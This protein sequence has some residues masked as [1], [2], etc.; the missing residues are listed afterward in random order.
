MMRIPINLAS[1]PFRRDRGQLA[2]YAVCGVVLIA[3]LGVMA[4]LIVNERDRVKE[5]R[6][7]VEQLNVELRN[8]TAEQAQVDATLREPANAEVLQRSLLLNA[9]IERKSISWAKIFADLEKV[10]PNDVRL[11]QIR[12][13]QI[14]SRNEVS[15]DME[16]GTKDPTQV[17][18]FLQNLENS[19]LFGA[20]SNPR[21]TPPTQNEPLNRYRITVNYAQKL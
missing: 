4:F 11:I 17:I 1:E 3:L 8:I 19:K 16:V 13:P 14:N 5:T 2:A 6:V 10:L 15:L 7:A 12:L 9:L 20:T 18:Q 21:Y